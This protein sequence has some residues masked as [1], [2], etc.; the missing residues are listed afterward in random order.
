MEELNLEDKYK[1]YKGLANLK[2]IEATS[3]F[4]CVRFRF[5]RLPAT[6]VELLAVYCASDRST[7]VNIKNQLSLTEITPPIIP[8]II[9]PQSYQV[10]T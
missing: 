3:F 9:P 2:S 10:D 6:A 1:V 8:P 5:D 7:Y 4:G